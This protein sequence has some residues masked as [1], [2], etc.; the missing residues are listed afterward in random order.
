MYL[1][2]ELPVKQG[3]LF[4][5]DEHEM[6]ADVEKT[7][8][9]MAAATITLFE[10]AILFSWLYSASRFVCN[11]EASCETSASFWRRWKQRI[12]K[13]PSLWLKWKPDASLSPLKTPSEW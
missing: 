12:T 7:S 1:V 10:V 2:T 3:M 9:L 13:S 4:S 6:D 11:G 8:D 5:D